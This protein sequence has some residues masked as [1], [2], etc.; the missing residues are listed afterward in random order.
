MKFGWAYEAPDSSNGIDSEPWDRNSLSHVDAEFE[1]LERIL[2]H[3]KY[4]SDDQTVYDPRRFF[5]R[6]VFALSQGERDIARRTD[7]GQR[8]AELIDRLESGTSGAS[9][10]TSD[11]EAPAKH[12]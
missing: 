7:A 2:E 10:A 5:N 1:S 3:N 11:P 12:P 4:R 9:A 8:L 6:R